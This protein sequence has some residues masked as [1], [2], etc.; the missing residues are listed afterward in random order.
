MQLRTRH[1]EPGPSDGVDTTVQ[2]AQRRRAALDAKLVVIDEVTMLLSVH[3]DII[4]RLLRTI[5]GA[6]HVALQ[7]SLSRLGPCSNK[8]LL[9]F[10]PAGTPHTPFGGK[11]FLASGDFRQLPPVVR[12]GG[13]TQIGYACVKASPLWASF[14]GLRLTHASLR[15]VADVPAAIFVETIGDGTA[16]HV[17]RTGQV[18]PDQATLQAAGGTH[19]ILLPPELFAHAHVF[20]DETAF[21]N[22]VHPPAALGSLGHAEQAARS[23]VVCPH[24]ATVDAHN[25][26]FLA[27]VPGPPIHLLAYERVP[28]QCAVSD[29]ALSTD[30]F[31]ASVTEPGKPDHCLTIKVGCLVTCMRN[32]GRNMGVSNGSRMEVLAVRPH[33][34]MCRKL[35]GD[36]GAVAIPRL[37]F[38]LAVPRSVMTIQRRQFPLKVA[39]ANT[40][41]RVQG[42][43]LPDRVGLDLRRPCFV[44]GQLYVCTSRSPGL[45]NLGF[46]V[47]PA[48]IVNTPDGLGL[49]LLSTVY[50]ELL[51]SGLDAA[52]R[53]PFV[54][55]VPFH[56]EVNPE[57]ADDFAF[58]QAWE[59]QGRVDDGEDDHASETDGHGGGDLGRPPTPPLL[60]DPMDTTP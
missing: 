60:D 4:D 15:N 7:V 21:R 25:A 27:D 3:L 41:H 37:L 57:D 19:S 50:P 51:G 26:A 42:M 1:R 38:D 18:L 43:S 6:C 32:L 5:M 22:W 20:T 47:D 48:D 49:L 35:Y 16:P 34:V 46:L 45:D 31:M 8:F 2:A 54:P 17:S 40:V 29:A 44:H 30:D 24:N 10:P 23:S 11:V 53:P 36:R 33:I 56:P 12:P 13:R 28:E 39:Y 55:P 59:G 58:M 52:P 9:P 14:H